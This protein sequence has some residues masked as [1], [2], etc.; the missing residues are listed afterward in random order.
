MSIVN[1]IYKFI[2]LITM[3]ITKIAALLVIITLSLLVIDL[4]AGVIMRYIFEYTP[5]WYEEIA[6]IFL[7]WLTFSGGIIA[8]EQS[9]NVS[10]NIFPDSLP[11]IMRTFLAILVQV[12]IIITAAFVVKYG[13]VFAETGKRGVFPSL[14]FLPLYA[15]YVAVPLGYA[16]ILIVSLRNL[17]RIFLKERLQNT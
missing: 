12:I 1:S 13:F 15:A 17:L 3:C 11:S 4:G 14:D 6:K 9:D 8:T 2:D 5:A 7:V 10:I 16:G